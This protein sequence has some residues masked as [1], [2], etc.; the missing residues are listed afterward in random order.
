MRGAELA[1]LGHRSS[2]SSKRKKNLLI[3]KQTTTAVVLTKNKASRKTSWWPSLFNS[4]CG[5]GS[6]Q[7][8]SLEMS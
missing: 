4:V 2:R 3:E 7:K 5:Y 1:N 6:R 8:A